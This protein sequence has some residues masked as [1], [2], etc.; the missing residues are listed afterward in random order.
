[1]EAH[2]LPLIELARPGIL[3]AMKTLLLVVGLVLL[4][5][6]CN[7][8]DSQRLARV[9]KKIVTKAEQMT[10]GA[11]ER[12]VGGLQNVQ[13][14]TGLAARVAARLRWDVSV[15]EADIAVKSEGNVVELRGN[16]ET[17]LQRRRAVE[18]AETTIGVGRVVDLIVDPETKKE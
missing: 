4:A 2:I 16:A 7:R 5:A 6:G 8:E 18:L 12:L 17:L 1:M 9:G 11:Q 13:D 3:R 10:G 15:A 14:G